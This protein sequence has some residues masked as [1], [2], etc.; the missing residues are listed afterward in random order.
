MFCSCSR[1]CERTDRVIRTDDC[2]RRSCRDRQRRRRRR[3][4]VRAYRRRRPADRLVSPSALRPTTATVFRPSLPRHY[5]YPPRPIKGEHNITFSPHAGGHRWPPVTAAV[6]LPF[7]YLFKVAPPRA[8]DLPSS[9][10]RRR[11]RLSRGR[12][13]DDDVRPPQPPYIHHA[14]TQRHAKRTVIRR[15]PPPPPPPPLHGYFNIFVFGVIFLS[16][17]TPSSKRP[18]PP[19]HSPRQPFSATITTAFVAN[20]LPSRHDKRVDYSFIFFNFIFFCHII[21]LLQRVTIIIII[22][23]SSLYCCDLF[24]S[25]H[26]RP[27]G[28]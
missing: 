21:L 18:S 1:V 12:V 24:F 13:A 15:A 16:S 19:P 25:I 23:K 20:Q 11:R 2:R 26:I 3:R 9:P 4:V 10:C 7:P 5:R 22:Y 8:D 27:F 6:P 28:F 17:R 14:S